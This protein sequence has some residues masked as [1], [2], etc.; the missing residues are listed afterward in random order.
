[1]ESIK[2]EVIKLSDDIMRHTPVE[3]MT[4]AQKVALPKIGQPI[5][6]VV[7]SSVN[8]R[9]TGDEVVTKIR[10]AIDAK[11]HGIRVDRLRKGKEQK[12]IIGCKN[13]EDIDKIVNTIR[14]TDTTL[15][16]EEKKNK[17]PL[18]I[19]KEVLTINTD[20]DIIK[21]IKTQ[22]SRLVA[23]IQEEDWRISVKYRKRCRNSFV[24]DVVLQVSPKLWKTLTEES[25]IH[26]DL[27]RVPVIDQSPLIQCSRCLAYGH[28]RRLCKENQDVCSHCSG[29]HLRKDCP[30]WMAGSAPA[31]HN[32]QVAKKDNYD[33]NTFDKN[34]PIRM[35]WDKLARS[36]VAYC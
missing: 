3:N 7:I 8:E 19:L 11:S 28:G 1:M 14:E 9:D 13:K 16:V 22:N 15:N 4:Y 30:M 12:V 6:T 26:I 31:C 29:P 27:Q 34:C 36:S 2:E 23:E 5:H 25:K 18:V 24:N 20:E 33:H 21:A 10:N 17:D 32:C 35:K